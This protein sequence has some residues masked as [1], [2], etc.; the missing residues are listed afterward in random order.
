MA[1]L[2]G[3]TDEEIN[4][5][6]KAW[7]ESCLYIL[8]KHWHKV[9]NFRIDKFLALLRHMFSQVLSFVKSGGYAEEDIKWLDQLLTKTM[10]DMRYSY[11]IALQICDVFIPELGKLDSENISLQ[12][13]S[14]LLKPFLSVLAKSNSDFVKKRIVESVFTPLLESN[15][16]VPDSD[17]ESSS[18]SEEENLA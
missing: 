9:D 7:F 13:L 11:G 17:E 3:S 14:G 8:N 5:R 10:L 1:S 2:S 16:T 18:S 15:V 12:S 6:K 4:E